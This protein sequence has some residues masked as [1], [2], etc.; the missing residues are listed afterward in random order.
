MLS[1]CSSRFCGALPHA[2]Q[3]NCVPLTPYRRSDHRFSHQRLSR[4]KRLEH[5]GSYQASPATLGILRDL[6]IVFEILSASQNIRR[7]V[8]CGGDQRSRAKECYARS[9]DLLVCILWSCASR[10]V[11]GLCSF[12]HT[13]NVNAHFRTSRKGARMLAD[14]RLEKLHYPSTHRALLR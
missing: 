8:G 13:D 3:G 5:G 12:S 9:R 2:P 1:I 14:A 11:T 4:L 7:L 10:P 6:K